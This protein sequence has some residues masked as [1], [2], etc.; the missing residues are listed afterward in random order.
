M[1]GFHRDDRYTSIAI[2]SFIVLALLMLGV[3]V[4]INIPYI[5]QQFLLILNVLRPVT[6]AFAFAYIC[7]PIVR[8]TESRILKKLQ[9]KPH[10]AR[11]LAIALTYLFIL[12]IV[13]ILL[14]MIVPQIIYNYQDFTENIV[15][16]I[17][18]LTER[19]NG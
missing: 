14:F 1:F 12:I 13:A 11:T 6:F 18:L 16:Y 7:N 19:I 9:A 10:L 15:R 8:Y 2:Y 4:C 3:V 17:N 5:F